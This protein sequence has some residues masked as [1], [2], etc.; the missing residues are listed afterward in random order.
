[1]LS[2]CKS[3]EKINGENSNCLDG[4]LIKLKLWTYHYLTLPLSIEEKKNMFLNAVEHYSGN[5]EN[6]IHPPDHVDFTNDQIDDVHTKEVLYQFLQQNLYII[7]Q[8]DPIANTQHNESYNNTRARYAFKQMTWRSSFLARTF[9][10]VLEV[11][12]FGEDLKG[13]ITRPTGSRGIGC[14][15]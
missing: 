12:R 8:C 14:S 11:N 2:F 5:H 1:M 10:A 13:G 6:C 3:F 15:S 4:L 7:E 9:V